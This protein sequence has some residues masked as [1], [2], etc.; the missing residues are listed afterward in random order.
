MAKT[1]AERMRKY[2]MN[3]TE[4]AKRF[5]RNKN[6]LQQQ[7]C[8]KKFSTEKKKM[9]RAVDSLNKIKK[10]HQKKT[11]T[12]SKYFFSPQFIGKAVSKLNRALPESADKKLAIVKQIAKNYGLIKEAAHVKKTSHL[13]DNEIEKVKEFYSSDLVSRQLPGRKDYVSTKCG[14]ENIKLQKRV[15]IMTVIEAYQL[16]VKKHTNCL[17]PI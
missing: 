6:K 12:L 17:F 4:D 7:S 1:A 14:D 15:L 8:R 13:S 11:M 2:R 16:F 9:I 3:M 5:N 10:R